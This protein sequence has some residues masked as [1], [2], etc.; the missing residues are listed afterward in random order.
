MTPLIGR[1]AFGVLSATLGLACPAYA[2]SASIPEGTPSSSPQRLIVCGETVFFTADDGLHGRELWSCQLDGQCAM[3]ADLDPGPKGSE[4]TS[5]TVAGDFLY[6]FAR[7]PETDNRAWMFDNRTR[8]VR[9]ALEWPPD[10]AP[11]PV[12]TFVGS[13]DH[14]Y[15]FTAAVGGR[16]TLWVTEPGNVRVTE[17]AA[18]GSSPDLGSVNIVLNDGS[19]LFR[20]GGTLRLVVSAPGKA[21]FMHADGL[22]GFAH[23]LHAIPPGNRAIA[24]CHKEDS[25]AEPWITDGT[26]Q[27]TYMLKDIAPGESSSGVD[28]ITVHQGHL[29][30]CADDGKTGAELW[31]SDGTSE[32]TSLVRDIAPGPGSSMP[33]YL[34]STAEAVYFVADDGLHGEELWGTDGTH[35]GTRLVS[36]LTPGMAGSGPWSLRAYQ[37]RLVFCANSAEFGEEVFVT[38]GIDTHV[39]RDI[40][41]GPESSGPGETAVVGDTLFF[42]CDDGVHG[43][44]LWLSDGT[45]EGTRMARDIAV[46]RFTPSLSPHDLA[47]LGEVVLFAARDVEHG[48]ELWLSDG[49]EPG[50][51]LL[52]D[53]ATGEESSS[54]SMLTPLSSCVV[55]SAE[56]NATGRELWVTDGTLEGTRLLLDIRPGPLG[57]DPRRLRNVNGVLYCLADD[58]VRQGWIWRSDGTPGGTAPLPR[59]TEPFRDVTDCMPFELFG[60]SYV[61]I[62]QLGGNVSLWRIDTEALTAVDISRERTSETRSILAAATEDRMQ[63]ADIPGAKELLV[64]IVRPWTPLPVRGAVASSGDLTFFPFRSDEHGTELWKTDGTLEGT[65]LVCDVYPGPASSGPTMLTFVGGVL[66][67]TADHTREGRILWRSEG[68]ARDTREVRPQSVGFQWPP[69]CPHEMVPFLGDLVVSA[70]Q[71]SRAQQGGP[72][73]GLI[74]PLGG[75]VEYVPVLCTQEGKTDLPHDLQP[76]GR[77]LFFAFDDG[78]HG[79]DLWVMSGDLG[80]ARLVKDIPGQDD[81]T[82]VREPRD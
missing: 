9:P 13:R 81:Q 36:D 7:V 23:T 71:P 52:A 75:S 48:D 67:F 55:F 49:T 60:D 76:V 26:V 51:R 1:L 66:Y 53:L 44:E 42:T 25:G 50:T 28:Q 77:Q 47:P 54:P 18:L 33:H 41:V 32:G 58:G 43:E 19:L 38:D 63:G 37:G 5:L 12:E 10:T 2:S 21:H 59:P 20:E 11:G 8:E 62:E 34:M 6:F 57:A 15:L 22:S 70:V 65:T 46:P 24:V 3:V 78:I 82:S 73:I 64:P 27:G 14:L 72:G 69:L 61:Y 17:I 68:E 16:K 29:Y 74:R 4:P 45:S 35:E 31:K 80:Q 30:F 56:T 39:L 40:V 79:D